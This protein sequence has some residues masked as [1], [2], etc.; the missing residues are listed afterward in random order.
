MSTF[1][2]M[3]EARAENSCAMQTVSLHSQIII[4]NEMKHCEQVAKFDE[5]I[6]FYG[7]GT[8]REFVQLPLFQ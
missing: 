3:A 5:H 6:H 1:T 2:F 4:R 8:H 7:R